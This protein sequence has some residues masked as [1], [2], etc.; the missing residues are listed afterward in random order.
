VRLLKF[1]L[2]LALVAGLP[3]VASTPAGAVT[4]SARGS[5]NQVQVWGATS[6]ATLELR[7]AADAVVATGVADAQGAFVFGVAP[8]SADDVPAGDDY[9]VHQ[10]A[11]T[12]N[13]VDVFAYD[14]DNPTPPPQSFYDDQDLPVPA[15]Y[16]EISPTDDDGY[17][18]ITTR[19]GT[20]LAANFMAPI[21]ALRDGQPNPDGPWPVI[22]NYSGYEPANPANAGGD[23]EIT[24]LR[25]AGFAVVGVNL[26]GTGCS[27]GVYSYFERLQGLDGYDVIEAIAAQ[28][29]VDEYPSPAPPFT[30]GGPPGPMI[31]MAGISFP[32]ISQLFVGRTNPPSL[33]AM[34]PLSVIADS[35]RSI[36]YPGGILNDGFATEWVAD[37]EES[38]QPEGQQWA[39][40]RIDGIGIDQPDV[41]CADNQRLKLQAPPLVSRFAPDLAFEPDPGDDLAPVT[42]V[43]DIDV[44][45]FIAGAFQDEQ[46]GG[47]WST[48]LDEYNPQALKRAVLFNGTHADALGPDVLRDLLEFLDIYVARRFPQQN[49]PLRGSAPAEL[50][51]TFGAP[52]AIAPRN[53]IFTRN[54]YETAQPRVVLR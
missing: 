54:G 46:T 30:A 53:N 14:Y 4:L 12:S 19:D 16:G 5:L 17:G 28:P 39:A 9:T 32:G 52:Y 20:T 11:D 33:A 43:D 25:A 21:V 29:W 27:G 34:S 22:V 18:Y 7:D 45:T 3:M 44:P 50:E 2:V 24:L 40:N 6:G 41:T 10:G 8:E 31:G 36:L 49:V 26:R 1:L 37:R 35:Y 51:G 23:A 13:A 47:H 38:A 48:F 42:F 15:N